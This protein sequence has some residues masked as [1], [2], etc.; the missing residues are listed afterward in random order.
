MT[1]IVGL[2]GT[3][4][5]NTDF[6]PTNY[7]E[8]FT[9]ME[10]NGSAPL[11]A[12]LAMANSQ[13]TDDPKYNHFRDQLPDKVLRASAAFTNVATTIS[14]TANDNTA[15]LMAGTLLFDP[16]TGELMRVTA[17]STAGATSITVSRGIGNGGTG[18]AS[19]GASDY[20]FFAGFADTE[21]GSAP[22]A[23]SFD[24]TVDYNYTQIFKT[25]VQVSGTLQNT[26]LRTGSKEQE[27]LMKAL[28]LHMS[29][30][31]RA[32]FFGKRDIINGT[33]ANPTRYT[34]GLLNLI[35]NVVD[36]ASG[37]TV[38]NAITEAEFDRLLIEQFFA[39]GSSEKVMFA[40]PRVV[41]NLMQ[42]AKN[43]WSPMQVSNAYG[44]QFTRYSTFAG[45]LLVQLHPMFRQLP[46]YDSTAIILDM[47][48]IGYR[49][50]A[51]R[52]TQLKRNVQNN[53]YDG[54]KHY[55]QTEAGLE[56]TSALPHYVLKNWT[57]L[58]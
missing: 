26:Y 57:K 7:R 48:N 42:I 17:D 39:W 9:L 30:I 36:A 52:D 40:G 37:F 34:G 12:L 4:Q 49:Y 43:K 51:G 21:A 13:S 53:D 16:A 47:A 19:S 11:Q 14:V 18:V 1:A 6:R 23:I 44:V 5:F 15:L 58:S 10:P 38:A 25:S 35:S 29:D 45:D 46:G 31:E 8:L 50:M 27:A 32:F 2:R 22:T 54:V 24:A 20:L 33:S 28:K 56:L 41:S 3:G 55:Y